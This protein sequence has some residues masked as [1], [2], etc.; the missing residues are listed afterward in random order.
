MNVFNVQTLFLIIPLEIL[1]IIVVV[2]MVTIQKI[3]N[4]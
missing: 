4:V 1:K 3:M 2:F